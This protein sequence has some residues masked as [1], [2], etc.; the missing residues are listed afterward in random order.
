MAV[1]SLAGVSTRSVMLMSGSSEHKL[2]LVCPLWTRNHQT[3]VSGLARFGAVRR[4][5][6]LEPR[7]H[8]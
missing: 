1:S 4:A 8:S 3:V 5:M 7:R 2:S 6:V